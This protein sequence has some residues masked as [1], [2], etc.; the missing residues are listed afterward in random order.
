MLVSR[1][2]LAR[3]TLA[4]ATLLAVIVA[5]AASGATLAGQASAGTVRCKVVAKGSPWAY[6]GQ[7][8]NR[9]TIESNAKWACAIGVKWLVRLTD[10]RGGVAPV[11]IPGWSCIAFV[12]FPGQCENKKGVIFFWNGK[13]R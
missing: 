6:K 2:T 12:S 11:R 3:L 5:S 4:L 8:G 1:S 13:L 9:Y 10:M 7:K